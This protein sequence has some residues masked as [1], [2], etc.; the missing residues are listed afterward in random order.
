MTIA[1]SGPV[2]T[3]V[4][5]GMVR[6]LAVT[7]PKRIQG[8]S[9]VPTMREA[10]ADVEGIIWTRGFAPKATPLAIVKGLEGEH[11][12]I[13]MQPDVAGR[14]KQIGVEAVGNSARSSP[15]SWPSISRAGAR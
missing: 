14:L 15:G 6:A 7:A 9:D 8:F 2:S 13:A 5:A 12:K 11:M 4:K 1:D 10:G 3:Q